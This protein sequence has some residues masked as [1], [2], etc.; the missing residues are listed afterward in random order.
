L[1]LSKAPLLE[2]RSPHGIIDFSYR[3]REWNG[4]AV[5]HVTQHLAP[6][7]SW[8]K[9][10]T[11]QAIVSVVL[12]QVNGY[13]EPRMHINNPTP[14]SRYDAGHAMFIPPNVEV[15]G[16]AEVST[17]AV[18]DLR[19][20]FDNRVI[21][22][23]LAEES[24]RQKRNEPLLMLYDDR[25]SQCAEL[26]ARECDA[27]EEAP[28]Y[29]ES[30]T[31]ALLTLLRTSS[32]TRVKAIRNG[33]ARGQLRRT[34]AYMEANLLEDIRLTELARV[35]GLSPSQFARAFKVSMGQT[36]HRWLVQ[37]RIHHAKRLMTKNGKPIS[38]AAH[39]AGFASQSYFTH[40]F[41]R[42]TGTTPR[43]WLRNAV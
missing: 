38:V 32:Q 25:I 4:V 33:L 41:R 30:L 43:H 22:H 39:L 17:S 1:P 23:L 28:L 13:C 40:V 31:T 5:Y 24:D 2:L 37:Q 27:D 29:G 9:L 6:G 36:P 18:R 8:Q 20:R 3:S 12:E 35:A 16:Y 34:V 19:L 11:N 10:C 7:R 14:R 21:E 26:L 15:W 42:V